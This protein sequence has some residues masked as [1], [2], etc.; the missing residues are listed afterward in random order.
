MTYYATYLIRFGANVDILNFLDTCHF[1]LGN[2]DE[3]VK[4]WTKSLEVSPNQEK[5]RAL[6]ESLKK[7]SIRL[8]VPGVALRFGAR[9][10]L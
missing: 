9:Y 7:N 5:I 8:P 6:V 3:A 2:R 4:A 1:Q 10:H